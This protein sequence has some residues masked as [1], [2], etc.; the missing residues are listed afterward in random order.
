M[1]G[2]RKE[3]N[4]EGKE[5]TERPAGRNNSLVLAARARERMCG[6]WLAACCVGDRTDRG[7]RRFIQFP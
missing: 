7:F 4:M 2:G 1:V 5:A 3:I 6:R